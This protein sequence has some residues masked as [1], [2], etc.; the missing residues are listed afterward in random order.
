M[1]I[2]I[3]ADT[4]IEGRDTLDA[5]IIRTVHNALD[6]FRDRITLVKVHLSVQSRARPSPQDKH[7]TMETRLEGA[8]PFAVA[9]LSRNFAEATAGA[10][11]E[12]RRSIERTLERLRDEHRSASESVETQREID[13]ALERRTDERWEDEGGSL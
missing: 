3:D 9:Y 4:L 13:D 1:K 11:K 7:A 8:Q 10:A 12:L 5:Q 6:P 2:Q